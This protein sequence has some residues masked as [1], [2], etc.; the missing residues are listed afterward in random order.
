M[1]EKYSSGVTESNTN[2]TSET[3]GKATQPNLMSRKRRSKSID[4]KRRMRNQRKKRKRK[5]KNLKLIEMCNQNRKLIHYQRMAHHFWERYNREAQLR[6]EEFTKFKNLSESRTIIQRLRIKMFWETENN[7][8][9]GLHEVNPLMLKDP[10]VAERTQKVYLGRGSF[11]I[12]QL[13]T[14][15]DFYV[16]VKEFMAKTPKRDILHE[17]LYLSKL[18]HPSVPYL[19]GVVSRKLPLR[20]VMQ[21]HGKYD[22]KAV[23]FRSLTLHRG[24]T[25]L[26]DNIHKKDWCSIIVQAADCLHYLH[27]ESNTLHNDFKEDNMLLAKEHDSW[28][29]TLID[30]GKATPKRGG[31]WYKLTKE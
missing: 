28:K 14:Y 18:S 31:K 29:L 21:F 13:K 15:R 4:E 11:G 3:K 8:D 7:A 2:H 16:A 5:Q 9:V 19:F 6:R 30:F 27:S 1:E 23:D 10:Q 26:G 20:L 17:A 12:V 25:E 24:M 22:P